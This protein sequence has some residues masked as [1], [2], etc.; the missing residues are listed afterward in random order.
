MKYCLKKNKG[1]FLVSNR[2]KMLLETVNTDIQFLEVKIKE[3]NNEED[4]N[5]Y[6]G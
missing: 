1:W 4:F 3:K 5:Q 2:L 6:Y